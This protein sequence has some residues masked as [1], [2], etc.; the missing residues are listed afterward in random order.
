[1]PAQTGPT[2]QTVPTALI[3]NGTARDEASS[4]EVR[5]E[6]EE[7]SLPDGRGDSAVNMLSIQGAAMATQNQIKDAAAVTEHAEVLNQAIPQAGKKMAFKPVLSQVGQVAYQNSVH[8]AAEQ[9]AASQA[10]VKLTPK[11]QPGQTVPLARTPPLIGEGVMVNANHPE[12]LDQA[13]QPVDGKSFVKASLIPK[14]GISQAKNQVVGPQAELTGKTGSVARNQTLSEIGQPTG[15]MA[16][17]SAPDLAVMNQPGKPE[18]MAGQK[19]SVSAEGTQKAPHP[20]GL[21]QNGQPPA[22]QPQNVQVVVNPVEFVRIPGG[23]QE[24]QAGAS[25]LTGRESAVSR[26]AILSALAADRSGVGDKPEDSADLKAGDGTGLLAAAKPGHGAPD[27]SPIVR[28]GNVSPAD[29]GFVERMVQEIRWS[30]SNNHREVVM[31]LNPEH[32][33]QMKLKVKE[34]GGELTVEMTVATQQAKALLE[35]R[36]D[37]IKNQLKTEDFDTTRFTVNVDVNQGGDL[38]A[39]KRPEPMNPWPSTPFIRETAQ[40]EPSGTLPNQP[41]WGDSGVGLYI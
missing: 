13:L 8:D 4:E 17:V 33:G 36:M 28:N 22:T 32:L 23:K 39:F 6:D 24:T 16:A 5:P 40:V 15:Q 10:G 37:E 9:E 20:D 11:L 7:P 29:R 30:G 38:S 18:E 21:L 34:S 2:A 26:A 3:K 27:T 14:E 1:K 35:S 25:L 12:S 19:P 41:V 31:R